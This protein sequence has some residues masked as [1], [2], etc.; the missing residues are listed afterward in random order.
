MHKC[1]LAKV[2]NN[3]LGNIQQKTPQKKAQYR[4]HKKTPDEEVLKKKQ[5]KRKTRSPRILFE[6]PKELKCPCDHLNTLSYKEE[7]DKRYIK[8]TNCELFRTSCASCKIPITG[9]ISA[10]NEAMYVPNCKNL[11]HFCSG[12]FKYKYKHGFCHACYLKMVN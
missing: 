4:K 8:T 7:S 6:D 11:T 9:E 10:D 1:E 3:R 12:L 2:I 5:P